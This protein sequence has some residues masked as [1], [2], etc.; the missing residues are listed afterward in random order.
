VGRLTFLLIVFIFVV[1]YQIELS[2]TNES[3]RIRNAHIEQENSAIE[4]RLEAMRSVREGDYTAALSFFRNVV[5]TRKGLLNLDTNSAYD[6]DESSAISNARNAYGK[7]VEELAGQYRALGDYANALR[8]LQ[9]EFDVSVSI[10]SEGDHALKQNGLA[11]VY[12]EIGDYTKALPLFQ[13]ALA[14]SKQALGSVHPQTNRIMSNL[15][16][17]YQ[18]MD[19]YANALPLLQEALATHKNALDEDASETDY[20]RYAISLQQLASLYVSMGDDGKA[21]PLY[22][23]A[24]EIWTQH[25]I[26]SPEEV[27]AL[28]KGQN[29]SIDLMFNQFDPSTGH[30]GIPD[31]LRLLRGRFLVQAYGEDHPLYADLLNS[32]ATLYY[33]TGEYKNALSLYRKS[34]EIR[35]K[36]L[37]EDHLD[38]AASVND[39]ALTYAMMRNDTDALSH[40]IEGQHI[41]DAVVHRGFPIMSEEQKLQFEQE[42][43]WGSFAMLSLIH[44]RLGENQKAIRAGMDAVSSR[45]SMLFDARARQQ[46]VIVHSLNPDTK[47]LWNKLDDTRSALANLLKQKP[48]RMKT[49]ASHATLKMLHDNLATLESQLASNSPLVAREL[50]QR[51]VV[52]KAVALILGREATLME[53]AKTKDY[54]WKRGQWTDSWRYLAF[55]LNSNGS[56]QL[57][58]LGDADTLER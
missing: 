12:H 28:V 18:S 51:N 36:T 13:Q 24:R 17:L 16:M 3:I 41:T 5:A 55:V 48:D 49:A 50:K 34:M 53:Y 40:F 35:K 7:S 25:L 10:L 43:A 47:T 2:N 54:D 14:T 30:I 22:R 58:D 39:I 11:E 57:V 9:D 6:F 32:I 52:S 8:V 56:V 1:A 27:K 46:K 21:L 15:A 44:S 42:L 20:F 23:E 37:G 45:K 19:D 38:Y 33:V 26:K 29:Q 4:Y 31:R